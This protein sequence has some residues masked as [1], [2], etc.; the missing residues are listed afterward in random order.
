MKA[1]KFAAVLAAAVTLSAACS[2]VLPQNSIAQFGI[3]VS[4]AEYDTGKEGNL[5][6]Q[7]YADYT[8]LTACEKTAV[9]AIKIP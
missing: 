7:K 5:T 1:K 6:Y 9:G 2:T 3:S 8:V 4:A